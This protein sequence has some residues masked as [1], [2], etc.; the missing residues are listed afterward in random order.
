MGV[1]V[2]VGSLRASPPPYQMLPW[3]PKSG[4]FAPE[5]LVIRHE[6]LGVMS[7]ADAF[8]R[9]LSGEVLCRAW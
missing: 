9:R 6:E 7:A 5:L 1:T 3:I 4:T 2:L 8:A